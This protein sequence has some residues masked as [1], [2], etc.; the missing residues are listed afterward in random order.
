MKAKYFVLNPEKKGPDDE[1]A[2]AARIAMLTYAEKI[3]K[4]DSDLSQEIIDWVRELVEGDK[5]KWKG[6]QP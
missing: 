4:I 1:Y 5:L 2:V 6:K 3:L